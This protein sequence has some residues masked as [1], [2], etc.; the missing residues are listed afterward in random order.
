MSPNEQAAGAHA[1]APPRMRAAEYVRM[2]TEHQQYSTE[3]QARRDPRVRGEARHRDR[4]G[5]TPTRARAASASTGA[6]PSSELIDATSQSGQA[7]FQVDPGLRRQPMGPLPGRRRERLLRVHLQARRHPG[8]LLRRAV[9]ERR[10]AGVDDRQE[11]QARDGGRVQP[12]ALGQGV[13]GPV[14]AD[15]AR[16]PPRRPRR[17]RASAHAGRRARASRRPSSPAASRRASRPTAS[18]LVPGPTEEVRR[19]PPDVPAVRRGRPERARDRRTASTRGASPTDLGGDVDAGD[20]PPGA[21][22]REVHRQ[23]RLQP[24]LLQAE[25]DSAL[26]TRPTCG[27][28]SDGAFE[29]IVAADVVLHRQGIMLEHVPAASATRS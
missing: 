24:R 7:D 14:P 4:R 29:A 17:V 16:L 20:G 18:I 6:T 12:R 25:E 9:R 1:P 5:P 2:S 26:R 22:Q 15:R 21:D 10:L 19:R 27:S 8:R 13:R 28:E 11:R 3:N 23:Q